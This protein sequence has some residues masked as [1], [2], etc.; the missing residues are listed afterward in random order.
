MTTELITLLAIA[1]V[2]SLVLATFRVVHLDTPSRHHQPP[3]SHQVDEFGRTGSSW[4]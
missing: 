3:R 4:H 1:T 2:A